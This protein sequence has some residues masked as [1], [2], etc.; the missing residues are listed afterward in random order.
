MKIWYT[1]IYIIDIRIQQCT[2]Y[3]A[4]PFSSI[5]IIGPSQRK[6]VKI[7]YG[8]NIKENDI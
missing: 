5:F 8:Y 6:D 4:T 2:A 7:K 1:M 3:L